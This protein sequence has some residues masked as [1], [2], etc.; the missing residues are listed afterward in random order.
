MGIALKKYKFPYL[1]LKRG[2]NLCLPGGYSTHMI[3]SNR[4]IFRNA[5]LSKWQIN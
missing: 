2:S 5:L 3:T 4:V 1:T